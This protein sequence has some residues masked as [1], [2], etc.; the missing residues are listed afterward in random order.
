MHV[1]LI[2]GHLSVARIRWDVIVVNI[3]GA[4]LKPV[5][6]G[7]SVTTEA[8]GLLENLILL[9]P[10]LLIIRCKWYRICHFVVST[11]YREL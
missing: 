3:S 7:R 10:F 11:T 4:P 8:N 5:T 2:K 1:L 6:H 9:I